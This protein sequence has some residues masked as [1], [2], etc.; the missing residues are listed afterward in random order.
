MSGTPQRRIKAVEPRP[1]YRV[2]VT[3][4]DLSPMVV[5]FADYV[6]RGGVFTPLVDENMFAEVRVG[7]RRRTIEWPNPH[8]DDGEPLIDVDAETL[9]Q[10]ALHQKTESW[11][12]R[13]VNQFMRTP[14]PGVPPQSP[15]AP[16]PGAT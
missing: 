10:M 8:G 9:L 5:S 11:F 1:G 13:L 15:P 14:A 7:E 3:W 12:H 6:R 16:H 2:A 4:D